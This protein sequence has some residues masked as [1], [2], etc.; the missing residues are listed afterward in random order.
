[1]LNIVLYSP[2]AGAR[3]GSCWVEV[4]AED[5][6]MCEVG[7]S[8]PCQP[9]KRRVSSC[10]AENVEQLVAEGPAVP[11]HAQVGI[12]GQQGPAGPLAEGQGLADREIVLLPL[13]GQDLLQ[14]GPQVGEE[15][16]EQQGAEVLPAPEALVGQPDPSRSNTLQTVEVFGEGRA[17]TGQEVVLQEQVQD[18]VD[19]IKVP[20]EDP[21]PTGAGLSQDLRHTHTLSDTLRA[22]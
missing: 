16:E 4:Q 9:Q 14:L 5:V 15:G 1:M 10:F 17:G 21:I 22:I 18:C 20:P 6:L 7:Q 13:L 12:D 19:L 2:L 11:Q 3:S 8:N